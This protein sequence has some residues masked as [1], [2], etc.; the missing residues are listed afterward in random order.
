MNLPKTVL[1]AIDF[2]PCSATALRTAVR[3]AEWRKAPLTAIH[4]AP[5]ATV[6]PADVDVPLNL[7]ALLPTD[8]RLVADARMALTA[9]LREHGAGA[10][11]RVVVESGN[12]RDRLLEWVRRERPDLLV[13]GAHS[14]TD[15]SRGVGTTAAACAQRAATQVVVVRAGQA[16]PFRSVVACV[17]FGDTSRLA[18]EHAISIAAEDASKLHILNIYSDPW[19]GLTAPDDIARNMPDFA[20]QYRKAIEGKL[21]KF[22]EP[23][24]HEL[25]VL[26][27]EYRAVQASS[28]AEGII[29][30]VTRAGCDLAVLGTRGQFNLRD[31]FWGSTAE[32]VVREAPCSVYAIK[33]PSFTGAD[34]YRPLADAA[35]VIKPAR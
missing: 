19:H 16:G 29:S 25:N 22:C 6:S 18:L 30:F 31:Y 23:L 4:V 1:V 5:A 26:K 12:P 17:D 2:S 10:A 9:F 24:A 15:A 21:R 33:P 14:S 35:A 28:H 34:A 32:R 20:D 13:V 27:P 3:I 11:T 7:A 8:D